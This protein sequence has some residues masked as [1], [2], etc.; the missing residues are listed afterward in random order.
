[1]WSETR[2]GS[3]E[4]SRAWSATAELEGRLLWIVGRREAREKV[5]EP[6]WRPEW[7]L[8]NGMMAA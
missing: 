4:I 8:R 7:L 1:M 3:D 5:G 2:S 6:I